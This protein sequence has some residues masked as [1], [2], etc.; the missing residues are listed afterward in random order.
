V[1][2]DDRII[3]D[4]GRYYLNFHFVDNEADERDMNIPPIE[5]IVAGNVR[6]YH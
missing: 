1:S 5:A 6:I 4:H 3:E 2:H